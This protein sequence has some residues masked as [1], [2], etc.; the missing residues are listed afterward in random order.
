MHV[1]G[2]QVSFSQGLR[3][4]CLKNLDLIQPRPETSMS[5][6][7]RSHSA[8]ARDKHVSRTQILVY[9]GQDKHVQGTQVSTSSQKKWIRTLLQVELR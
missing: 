7:L 8:K 4:A 1:L 3:Q 5:Q 2:T 9:Q 6:E